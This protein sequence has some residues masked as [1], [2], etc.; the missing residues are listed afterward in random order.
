MDYNNTYLGNNLNAL[1]ALGNTACGG[2]AGISISAKI[3]EKNYNKKTVNSY[4]R[5]CQWI[6]DGTFYPVDGVQHCLKAY[7]LD[8]TKDYL[9]QKGSFWLLILMTIIVLTICSLL[10]PI[11]WTYE[12]FKKK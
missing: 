9:F 7:G 12:V 11:F 2:K 5:F 10:A 4:W 8:D 3:G 6:V 1:S